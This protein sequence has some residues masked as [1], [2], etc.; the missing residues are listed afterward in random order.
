M[1]DVADIKRIARR[2]WLDI[3]SSVGRIP[4]DALDGRHHPC[5]WCG[6][7]DRFRLLDADEGAVICSRCFASNNGDGVAAIMRARGWEFSQA[8]REIEK[9]LGIKNGKPKTRERKRVS[10][11]ERLRRRGL[12]IASP[13]IRFR[14]GWL[15]R[16]GATRDGDRIVIPCYDPDAEQCSQ[17]TIDPRGEGKFRKG[18]LAKGKPAGVFLPH[19]DG[20]PRFPHPGE[21]WLVVEGPKDAS[22]LHKLGELAIGLPTCQMNAKFA[23]LLAGCHVTIVPDLDMAG[24]EGSK[25]TAA[26]LAGVAASVR[27]ARLPGKIEESK[28]EDVR[29]IL[30]KRDGEQLV[31]RAIVDAPLVDEKGQARNEIQYS[32]ISSAELANNNYHIQYYIDNV[33]AANQPCVV[34]GPYKSL[35]TSILVDLAIALAAGVDFLGEFTVP[36]PLRVAMMSGE[37]GMATL[38]DTANRIASASGLKLVDL[39]NLFWTPQLPVF[40]S[41]E[42]MDALARL[43]DDH[44]IRVLIVDPAY[45]AMPLGGGDKANNL[46]AVG[47]LLRSVN[48]MC[49][50][51]GVTPVIAHHTAKSRI[52][53]EPAELADLAWSGWAEWAR[54]WI[55]INRREKYIP[56]SDGLHQLWLTIGGSAGHSSCWAVDVTEGRRSDADGRRWELDVQPASQERKDRARNKKADRDEQKEEQL[57]DDCDAVRRLLASQEKPLTR[58]RMRDILRF[59]GSRVGAVIEQLLFLDEIIEVSIKVSHQTCAAYRLTNA[60]S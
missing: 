26:R 32:L 54:Q 44:E 58:R 20:K 11:R 6:G 42:H 17:L 52:T 31:R 57:A 55:L 12:R 15:K 56:E 3:L 40:G 10:A 35:K 24:Q 7:K 59:S 19:T 46:F 41:L 48:R 25:D 43:I 50:D 13:G 14:W 60:P 51:H 53:H 30:A 36:K 2:Q 28:G 39:D 4:R 34:G 49:E 29:D 38:Q 37:S 18:L 22:A 5:P 45:L 8:M 16:M 9:H 27:I 21:R 23:R 33:L 47:E 1:I